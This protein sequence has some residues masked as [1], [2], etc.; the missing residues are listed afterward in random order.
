MLNLLEPLRN[1]AN[2][3]I[4]LPARYK[5]PCYIHHKKQ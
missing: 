3:R 1:L 5:V 4:R 2:K